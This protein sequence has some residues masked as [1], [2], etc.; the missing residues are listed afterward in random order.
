MEGVYKYFVGGEIY[1][2][3][4][5]VDTPTCRQRCCLFS[6]FSNRESKTNGSREIHQQGPM[7]AK[8]LEPFGC[9]GRWFCTQASPSASAGL[10]R[11]VWVRKLHKD[12][13]TL[14]QHSF[15]GSSSASKCLSAICKLEESLWAQGFVMLCCPWGSSCREGRGMA[16]LPWGLEQ[17]LGQGQIWTIQRLRFR[18]SWWAR[19][20]D[21]S[22]N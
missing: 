4:D 13:L 11:W 2:G 21:K 14:H 10:P 15:A 9:W 5:G 3:G 8:F 1:W 18:I 17:F 22:C 12:T 20:T 16:R 6:C 19:G 7:C